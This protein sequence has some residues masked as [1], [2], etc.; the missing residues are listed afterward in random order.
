MNRKTIEENIKRTQD[1]LRSHENEVTRSL[2]RLESLKKQLATLPEQYGFV[3]KR[4]EGFFTPSISGQ[5]DLLLW[6]GSSTPDETF[7][8]CVNRGVIS[9]NADDAVEVS[10]Y[11][12]VQCKLANLA[13]QLNR[14]HPTRN[15]SRF[16]IFAEG[17]RLEVVYS[18][19][20]AG[21]TFNT[22][23]AADKALASLSLDE[24]KILLKGI[25]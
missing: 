23:E 12:Q 16:E 2:E 13:K 11:L 1:R 8:R 5:K 24:R 10:K 17:M 18:N 9:E 21:I 7:D 22:Q 20:H 3:P 25:R 14:T 15:K 4:L 19:V 6:K